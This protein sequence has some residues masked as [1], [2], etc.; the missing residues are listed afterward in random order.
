MA[1][2]QQIKAMARQGSGKGTARAARR[3]GRVP[4]VLYGDGKPSVPIS[5]DFA[6]IRQRIHA[7]R[8]L[9][10]IFELE[11]DGQKQRV[12]PREFQLDPI[13]EQPVHVDFMRLGEGATIRVA[14]P[15]RVKNADQSP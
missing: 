11:L 5:L 1:S 10:T 9:T 13:R 3:D 12:I 7:G 6:D 8:F 15:V 2:V 14:V 4:G